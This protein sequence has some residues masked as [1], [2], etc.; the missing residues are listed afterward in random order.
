VLGADSNKVLGST[1]F[2]LKNCRVQMAGFW[3]RSAD[4]VIRPRKPVDPITRSDPSAR[5]ANGEPR[6]AVGRLRR[7]QL[8]QPPRRGDCTRQSGY[9]VCH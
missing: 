6:A 3:P 7:W 1:T 2:V 8:R 5:A 4:R 9:P